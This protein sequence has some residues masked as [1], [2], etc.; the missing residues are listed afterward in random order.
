MSI[1]FL[2]GHAAPPCAPQG[3]CACSAPL[4]E[5]VCVDCTIFVGDPNAAVGRRRHLVLMTDYLFA[6]C[7]LPFC[8]V[9]TS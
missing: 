9:R 3:T 5:G 8:G 1:P 2:R 7:A 4:H 6:S